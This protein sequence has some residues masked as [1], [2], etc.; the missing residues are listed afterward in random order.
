MTGKPKFPP[1]TEEKAQIVT[2]AASGQSENKISQAIG[3]SR[4]LV[5][6]VLAEPEVQKA[7]R[8]EKAELSVIFRQKSRVVVASISE[9]DISKASLQQK[10]ISSAVLL[11]KSLLLAGEAPIS[12]NI[13]VLLGVADTIREKI[14]QDAEDAQRK[15]QETHALPAAPQIQR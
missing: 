13:Q 7:V 1:T 12:V 15:W 8:D 5:K 9:A 4:H 14:N 6:H 11:D 10:S 2:L 3:R